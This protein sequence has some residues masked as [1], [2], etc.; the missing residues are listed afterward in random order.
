MHLNTDCFYSCNLF[1]N[2]IPKT[3]SVMQCV[4]LRGSV[5]QCVAVCC[6]V[7]QCGTVCCSVLQC[8]AVF[9]SVLQCVAVPCSV[10]QCAALCYSCNLFRN[11]IPNADLQCDAV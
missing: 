8:V 2:P 7:L 9:C 11:P 4:A 6:S 10:L 1:R 5:L 3:C